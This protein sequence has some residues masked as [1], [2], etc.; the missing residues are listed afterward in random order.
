MKINTLVTAWISTLF[1]FSLLMISC[2]R[3]FKTDLGTGLKMTYNG[4]GVGDSYLTLDGE[5]FNSR[6]IPLGKDIAVVLEEVSG[7]RIKDGSYTILFE[8]EVTDA[9]GN[10][11]LQYSDTLVEPD[12][13]L[14]RSYLTVA[15]PMAAGQ[16]YKWLSTFTDLN[17]DGVVK[18]AIDLD[19]VE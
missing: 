13:D 19:I 4:V 15:E 9:Q 14:L 10:Y 1:L 6:R 5:K 8:T 3:G 17:G 18:A 12:V 16:T 7:L 11:L 2:S